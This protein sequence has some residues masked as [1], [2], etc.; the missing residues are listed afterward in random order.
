MLRLAIPAAALVVLA[1]SPLAAGSA[2]IRATW[3]GAD[4]AW[5]DGSAWS[6]DLEPTS[7]TFPDND[8]VDEFD[9][10]VDASSATDSTATLGS[11]AT[12][13]SVSISITDVSRSLIER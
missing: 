9:V 6:F 2:Q 8:A 1:L 13:R 4:G 10:Q 11:N 7:A 3:T 12:V 5:E